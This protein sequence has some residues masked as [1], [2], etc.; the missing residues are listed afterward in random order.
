[1][2][3]EALLFRPDRNREIADRIVA[4]LKNSQVGGLS[5]WMCVV[6]SF[7]STR[8]EVDDSFKF[9]VFPYGLGDKWVAVIG[10]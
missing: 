6:G 9:A 8:F 2:V 10:V 7:E 1:M 4:A 3:T 5:K